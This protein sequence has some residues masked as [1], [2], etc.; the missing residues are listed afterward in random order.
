MFLHA[1]VLMVVFDLMAS[2]QRMAA[3]LETALDR[4]MATLAKLRDAKRACHLRIS[5]VHTPRKLHLHSDEL[6][7]SIGLL[8][9]AQGSASLVLGL[10]EAGSNTVVRLEHASFP[11]HVCLELAK[12]NA[13]MQTHWWPSV[14]LYANHARWTAVRTPAMVL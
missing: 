9:R 2:A 11:C 14:M 12:S 6:V 5:R 13:C 7:G 8:L 3:W 4:H 10:Q 1:Q